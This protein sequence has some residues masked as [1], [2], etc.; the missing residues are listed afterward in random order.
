MKYKL[1]CALALFIGVTSCTAPSANEQQILTEV[2]QPPTKRIYRIDRA[3]YTI[4]VVDGC[5][6]IVSIHKTDI[7]HK[8]DCS[9]PIHRMRDTIYIHDTICCH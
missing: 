9:N 1:Y 4:Q 2:K 7:A 6:Y 5:E 3:D 8:G